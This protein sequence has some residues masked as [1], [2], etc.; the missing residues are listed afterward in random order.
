MHNH[1]CE[2]E[3]NNLKFCKK[4]GVAYCEDC[5][6]EWFDKCTQNHYGY[7]WP[8]YYQPV[9]VPSLDPTWTY[10]TCDADVTDTNAVATCK[11]N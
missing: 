7:Y 2:C 10:A 4:C 11:H 8:Y 9:S 6:R 1:H 3:H 5:G